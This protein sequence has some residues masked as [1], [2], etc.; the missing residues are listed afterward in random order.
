MSNSNPKPGLLTSMRS[1]FQPDGVRP[2]K[3]RSSVAAKMVVSLVVILLTIAGIQI[4]FSY[5]S[6]S[7]ILQQEAEHTLE[8][9]LSAYET[10][11]VAEQNAAEAIALSIA[12]RVDVQELYLKG[13]RDG[14]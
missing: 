6:T 1:M 12:D 11:I 3:A 14:L 13:D 10:K 4:A 2:G 7:Q 9:H 5:R 8:G